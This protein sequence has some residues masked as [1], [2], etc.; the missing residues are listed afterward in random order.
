[1]AVEKLLVFVRGVGVDATQTTD[2]GS[3]PA[4]IVAQASRQRRDLGQFDD[5]VPQVEPE[6]LAGGL[7]QIDGPQVL[8]DV[9]AKG[10]QCLARPFLLDLSAMMGQLA[11]A[12]S[13]ARARGQLFDLATLLRQ[14]F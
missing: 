10:R 8:L 4:D 2:A 6:L 3:E 1:M 13:L 7:G 9:L 11:L 12:E 5:V 14:R